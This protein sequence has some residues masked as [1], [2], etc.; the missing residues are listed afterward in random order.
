MAADATLVAIGR[1][2]GERLKRCLASA[3]N[4]VDHIVYVDSGSTDGSLE[5]AQSVGAEVVQLDT[6]VKF[7]AA[8]ARNAGF[9]R[10]LEL[11]PKVRFVQFVDGDCEVV[12]GW[13]DHAAAFLRDHPEVA[14]VCGRR[15]ERYPDRSVYNK[16][17]DMEWAR[18][19]GPALYCGGDVMV[20]TDAFRKV[21]GF[22]ESLIAGEE[23]ELCV[24]LRRAGWSIHV[25][26]AEMTLHDAAMTSF[27][28][29][30]KR[31]TRSGYAYA[32]G[33]YLHGA[34]PERHWVWESCRAWIWGLGPP[35]T[36]LAAAALAG[37]W[38]LLIL[39]VYPLQAL[40]QFRKETG[41]LQERLF[42]SVFNLLSRFPELAGQLRFLRDRLLRRDGSLI[43]YK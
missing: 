21:G 8:R 29:W 38:A 19:P 7:T 2:E 11:Q 14:A 27:G 43:E 17:C 33:A 12:P 40:R 30:W 28:Q 24:R 37:P 16:L 23:P 26:D 41:T 3:A 42:S 36:V 1:N 4:G 6:A 25:L 31:V 34:G 35:L 15:R 22:R 32:E 18:P 10:A 5:H 20:R 9:R 13:L 39:L